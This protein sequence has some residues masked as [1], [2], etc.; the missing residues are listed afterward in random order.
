MYLTLASMETAEQNCLFLKLSR[1]L[2]SNDN[3]SSITANSYFAL[4][5]ANDDYEPLLTEYLH[6]ITNLGILAELCLVNIEEEITERLYRNAAFRSQL[7]KITGM[8]QQGAA[9]VIINN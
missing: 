1:L 4:L 6:I 7:N 9:A 2:L 5:T 8:W 3:L